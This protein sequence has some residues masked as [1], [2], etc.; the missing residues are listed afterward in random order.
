MSAFKNHRRPKYI[1]FSKSGNFGD[2][3]LRNIMT[4]R[5]RNGDILTTSVVCR[6]SCK[7]TVETK[8]ICNS[9]RNCYF[10]AYNDCWLSIRTRKYGHYIDKFVTCLDKCFL[11]THMSMLQFIYLM[12]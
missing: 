3:S 1:K 12:P 8:A 5:I 9:Q 10:H 7:I 2:R 4:L 6:C 11:F